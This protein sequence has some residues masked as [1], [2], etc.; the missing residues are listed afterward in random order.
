[1]STQLQAW[2]LFANNIPQ[3]DETLVIE[4]DEHHFLR[5]VLRLKYGETLEVTDG[6]GTVAIAELTACEKQKSL[7]IVKNKTKNPKP[8]HCV[9][10]YVGTPKP[11][12]LEEVVALATE[13]G[14]SQIHFFRAQ[15]TQS[16]Q[17]TRIDRLHKIMRESMRISRA[18][19]DTEIFDHASLQEAATTLPSACARI[20]CDES[21]LYEDNGKNIQNHLLNVLAEN[22]VSKNVVIFI[23]PESSFTNAEK[24]F[25]RKE[26]L[27]IPATLG[28]QIL[29]VPTAA[30]AATSL[31]LGFLTTRE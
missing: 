1:M 18:A 10:L 11:A 8:Q 12:A 24:D 21:P 7:C 16:K 22:T 2:R 23:G 17:P 29:R 25:M 15:K 19:W 4:G 13:L 26:T 31:C 6:K 14:A 20:L 5:T 27:A 28:S 30:A 9:S 3:V